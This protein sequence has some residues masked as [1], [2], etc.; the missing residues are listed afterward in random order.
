MITL[1][2]VL[3]RVYQLLLAKLCQ[4]ICTEGVFIVLDEFVTSS[5]GFCFRMNEVDGVVVLCCLPGRGVSSTV[6]R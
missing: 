4:L 1:V 2:E 6:T 3:A 5:V